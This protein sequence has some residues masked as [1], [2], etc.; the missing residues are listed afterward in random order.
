VMARGK[1]AAADIG[2]RQQVVTALGSAIKQRDLAALVAAL[3]R[4]SELKLTGPEVTMREAHHVHARAHVH[5]QLLSRK[6][7]EAHR[8][9]GGG[10]H[11][12]GLTPAR[13]T[14]DS[15]CGALVRTLTLTRSTGVVVVVVAVAPPQIRWHRARR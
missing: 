8:A 2:Q 9:R 7:T 12:R 11:S 14:F 4:A 10:K 5:A 1:A 3:D 6:R 15:V 13:P